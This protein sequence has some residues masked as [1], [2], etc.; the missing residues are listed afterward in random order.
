[1]D[2]NAG[3]GIFF[4]VS[5]SK[6]RETQQLLINILTQELSSV[7]SSYMRHQHLKRG[8]THVLREQARKEK[9]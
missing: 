4:F 5:M 6:N 9:E 2:K 1:M 7:L 3:F 8:R